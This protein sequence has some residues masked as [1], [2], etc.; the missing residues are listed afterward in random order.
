MNPKLIFITLTI[1]AVAFEVLGDIFLKRWSI[2]NKNVVLAIGLA[3]Y[4]VGTIFWAWSLKY[5]L[6]SRA[7]SIFTVVNLM[8]VVLV[9]VLVF[10]EQL[11]L[12][13]KFG[14]ALGVVSV[15]LIEL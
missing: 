3:I 14:I 4:F 12:Q 9:G 6:L 11:T 15:L 1:T 10:N 5:E 8:A 2:E 13:Q 7:I